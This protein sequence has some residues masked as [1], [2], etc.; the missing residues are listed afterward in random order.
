MSLDHVVLE[1]NKTNELV[2]Y[3][4][5]VFDHPDYDISSN[6]AGKEHL[7]KVH[8]FATR[9]YKDI[10]RSE[11]LFVYMKCDK[12]TIGKVLIACMMVGFY[13][14]IPQENS[15]CMFPG[16]KHKAYL[17]AKKRIWNSVR[18]QHQ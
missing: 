11:E 16:W 7:N 1:A 5:L 14:T 17:Y 6:T 13:Q 10:S 4:T 8:R 12:E 2:F 9:R 18:N 15:I 3:N